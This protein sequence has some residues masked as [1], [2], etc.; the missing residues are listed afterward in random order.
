LQAV[1]SDMIAYPKAGARSAGRKGQYDQIPVDVANNV[2]RDTGV[3]MSD[4][5]PGMI[6][7]FCICNRGWD[8]KAVAFDHLED[9]SN[10]IFD[11]YWTRFSSQVRGVSPLS[12]AINSLQDVYEGVDWNLAKAKA[13]ALFGIALMRDYAGGATD[14]EEVSELGAASGVTVGYDEAE[15]SASVT[16][17]GT[18]SVAASLQKIKPDSMMLLDMETKGR[19]E[20][21]ESK[22]PS[23]EFQAFTELVL[24]LVLLSLDIPYTALNSTSASFAGMIADNNMYEVACGWKRDKNKWARQDYSDWLLER[25]WNDASD[26]WGLRETAA[27]A[28]YNR[29]RDIQEEVHW[30]PSGSPWLQKLQQVQGDIKAISVGLDNPI[31]ACKRNGGDV[32]ENIDKIAQVN[33]YAKEKGV[34]LLIGEPGQRSVNEVADEEREGDQ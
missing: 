24:R 1:E 16:D 32:F 30:V 27:K 28:G 25:I 34:S 17:D 20:T 23:Q 26:E 31:D 5:Y 10:V 4:K 21:I 29:L 6:E 11:A 19:V 18:K 13:H 12:T 2:G 3:I 9:Q 14:Q 33:E 7:K 22:T 15:K 8:G